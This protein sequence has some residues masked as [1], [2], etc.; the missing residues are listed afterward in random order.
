MK[1]A[2]ILIP[3]PVEV[4][5]TIWCKTSFM[6]VPSVTAL[7]MES[8]V[9]GFTQSDKVLFVVRTAFGQRNLVVYLLSRDQ[10][11]VLLT[12]FAKRMRRR[13]SVTDTFP[14]SAVSSA[15]SGI[16][17]VFFVAFCFFLGVFSAE[18][19]VGQHG[20]AGMGAGTLGFCG[21]RISFVNNKSH[22]RIYS[23]DGFRFSFS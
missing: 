7:G 12:Q 1:A 17:I 10:L 23:R 22:R 8:R 19:S 5:L 2:E 11:S 4:L 20:T 18:P 6:I 3:L 15:D 16:T 13:I 9:T 21:H 14:R